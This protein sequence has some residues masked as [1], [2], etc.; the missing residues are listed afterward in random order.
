LHRTA[1]E[2]C[3]DW[4]DRYCQICKLAWCTYAGCSEVSVHVMITIRKVTCYVLKIW[5]NLTAW[6][7]TARARGTLDSH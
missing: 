3:G 1:G 4:R 7:M 2:N 5:L 6:Q